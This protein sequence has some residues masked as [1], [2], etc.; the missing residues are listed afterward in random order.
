MPAVIRE[1][2]DYVSI[3]E[4]QK[5]R[6]GEMILRWLFVIVLLVSCGDAQAAGDG[7]KN[8]YCK[9][10]FESISDTLQKA[11][12]LDNCLQVKSVHFYKVADIEY[13]QIGQFVGEHHFTTV[14]YCNMILETCEN[15]P[16]VT[17]F[18][19]E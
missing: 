17:R 8:A 1:K 10:Y 15:K 18:S 4:F 3:T 14:D 13:C 11:P 5:A 2:L 12:K 6:G 9:F 16:V 7:C 19:E